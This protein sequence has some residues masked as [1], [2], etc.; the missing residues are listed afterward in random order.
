VAVGYTL[1]VT[2]FTTGKLSSHLNIVGQKTVLAS[3]LLCGRKRQQSRQ[4]AVI[5]S[6]V[7]TVS[8][9]W[10]QRVQVSLY[11]YRL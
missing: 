8:F 10:T 11:R 9:K 3:P 6:Q 2:L 5:Q 4:I 7:S 1:P